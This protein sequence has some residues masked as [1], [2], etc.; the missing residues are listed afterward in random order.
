MISYQLTG[1]NFVIRKVDD[2]PELRIP[3]METVEGMPNDNPDF[4]AYKD[5]LVSGGVSIPAAVVPEKEAERL[6]GVLNAHLDAVAGQRRYDNRFT[7]SIRAGYPGPF[8]EEGLAFAAHM[9][10]CNYK[11]YQIMAAVKL[12]QRPIPGEAE[13]I[14]EM[15]LITWPPS[16]IPP[17]ALELAALAAADNAAQDV[18]Q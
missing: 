10:A 4:L 18:P 17:D 8:R 13:L 3:T 6:T 14:S 5:F 1:E 15:P 11:A 7:C 16:P 9:D 2:E 12:G